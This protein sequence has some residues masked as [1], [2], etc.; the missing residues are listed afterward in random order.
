MNVMINKHMQ[1]WVIIETISHSSSQISFKPY[2]WDWVS[3]MTKWWLLYK[4]D[5]ND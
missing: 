4:K 3:R 5:E 2:F 1:A